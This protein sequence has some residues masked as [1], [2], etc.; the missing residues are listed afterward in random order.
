[1]SAL[2]PTYQSVQKLLQS[3]TYSIDEFQREYKWDKKNIDELIAD[4]VGRF[5]RSYAEG[6][7][8]Q[9]VAGYEDYF[10]GSIIVSRRNGKKYLVDGQQRVTSLTLLLI[11]L[12][13]LAKEKG[14]PV[15]TT[16]A[17]LIHSDS[18]GQPCFNLDIAE[19]RPVLDAL[20]HG[21]Q[22]VPDG[23]EE[24]VQAMYARYADISSNRKLAALGSA[25]PHFVYWLMTKVGLIEIATTD[26][27]GAYAIFETMNDRGKPL[28]PVDMMKAYL[29]APVG[30]P[31][32]RHLAN[33]LWKQQIHRLTSWGE[34]RDPERDTSCIKAWLRAQYAETTRE[35][36]EGAVDQDWELIGSRFHHWTRDN[37]SRLRL[38]APERN[39]EFIRDEI[40]FLADA[41]LKI[42]DASS[43]QVPGLEAVYYNAHNDFTWQ[44]TVLLAPLSTTDTE[45]V[46]NKKLG[47][48][49]TY[50]DIWLMR[51]AANYFRVGYSSVSYAMYALCKEI[52]RKPL[53]ELVPLLR[54][55]LEK[56]ET[57]FD[58]NESKYRSGIDDYGLSTF[59]RRYIF[60]LLARLTVATE[61]G[62]GE[63][64]R[65]Q[66]Y[67][68]R[69]GKNPYDIEHI[70][71]DDYSRY[72]SEFASK[73]EFHAA[74]NRVAG[75]L[76]LPADV[77]RSLQDKAYEHKAMVYAGQNLYAA[78]LAEAAYNHRPQFEQF[79]TKNA[80]PFKP[81]PSFGKTDQLDRQVLVKALIE[82]IWSPKRLDAFLE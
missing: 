62:A 51:R 67:V 53:G 16:V 24:S 44:N 65:F 23:K 8:T 68:D 50:L 42:L 69:G 22:F 29:V 36:K 47:A 63:P 20:F 64:N 79:R 81:Y 10:L 13:R 28:S 5:R 38:G 4:L 80:L 40:H 21:S 1:M 30:D 59:T 26:D 72:E 78:S 3:Q 52:R 57:T 58:G 74:R 73:E 6:H 45:Q 9:K 61:E 11:H 18:F 27:E 48:T 56:D 41:Y 17:P 77:N 25:F 37:H 71:P 70:W 46:V 66:E 35:R 54:D 14:L 12:H 76:L 60:H 34:D 39:V 32:Q 82:Q 43:G 33:Q 55:R 15:A 2:E 75:L 19:R 31:E 49:A 7:D